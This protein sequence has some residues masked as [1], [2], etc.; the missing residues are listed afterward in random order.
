[1]ATYTIYFLDDRQVIVSFDLAE[2]EDDRAAWE[3]APRL[4]RV[5]TGSRNVEIHQDGRRVPRPADLAWPFSDET[6]LSDACAG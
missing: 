5:R 4:L 6:G 1:M 3:H 2:C